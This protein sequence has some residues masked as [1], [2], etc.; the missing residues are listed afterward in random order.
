[1][2]LF[3]L[4]V[5]MGTLTFV[6]PIRPPHTRF[7]QYWEIE[8]LLRAAGPLECVSTAFHPGRRA[9]S[10]SKTFPLQR[11]WIFFQGMLRMDLLMIPAARG[12]YQ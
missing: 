11:P 3:Q 8:R 4:I 6:V 2:M 9:K 5:A 10:Q 12:S 7:S 1:M